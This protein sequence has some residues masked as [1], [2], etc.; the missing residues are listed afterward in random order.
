MKRR[1]T[2]VVGVAVVLT[3]AAGCGGDDLN[4]SASPVDSAYAT[5]TTTVGEQPESFSEG[6]YVGE[7]FRT[8]EDLVRLSAAVIDGT[9][10]SVRRGEVVGAPGDLVQPRLVQVEIHGV[11][12]GKLEADTIEMVDGYWNAGPEHFGSFSTDES[13]F[14]QVGERAFMFIVPGT[15]GELW[16]LFRPPTR[17]F[18]DKGELVR[19]TPDDD[20]PVIDELAELDPEQFVERMRA[21]ERRVQAGGDG[22]PSE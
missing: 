22:S 12:A 13:R 11:L 1:A 10:Q 14:G 3:A 2:A 7:T 6:A 20:D 21:A 4:S 18:I 17:F 5:A 19:N 15:E 9:I 16:Y 8:V